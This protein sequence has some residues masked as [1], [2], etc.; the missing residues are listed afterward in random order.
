MDKPAQNEIVDAAVSERLRQLREKQGMSQNE[1]A[2]RMVA[3]GVSNYSQMTVSRTE[4]GLRR[5]TAGELAVLAKLLGAD[6]GDLMRDEVDFRIA[7]V[8]KASDELVSAAE[9]VLQRLYDLAVAIDD[10]GASFDDPRNDEARALLTSRLATLDLGPA[11]QRVVMN[12]AR[13]HRMARRFEDAKPGST[14]KHAWIKDR[15]PRTTG[16]A[17]RAFYACYELEEAFEDDDG[18]D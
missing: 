5:V 18:L 9:K 14:E 7:E 17:V 4:K 1:L 13:N 3:A 16:D 8:D 11:Q 12:L 15:T 10:S 2:K 6:A